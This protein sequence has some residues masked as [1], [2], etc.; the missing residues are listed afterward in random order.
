MGKTIKLT[1]EEVEKNFKD[2]G[3]ILL[4]KEYKNSSTKMK[5]ICPNHGKQKISVNCLRRGIRCPE[6]FNEKLGNYH[7]THGM[8]KTKL[9][10]SYR[11]MKERCYNNNYHHFHRYG[12]RGIKVCD[13][14]LDDFIN[15]K[16][17]AI[18]NKY[19]ES[20]TIDRIDKDKNYEPNNCRWITIQEQQ[21]NKCSVI[22]VC[23]D[24]IKDTI[25]GHSERLGIKH[26]TLAARLRRKY[27]EKKGVEIFY[28]K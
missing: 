20:L 3:Y 11:A 19:K 21:E 22:V 17:W 26:K 28:V 25:K 18:E 24:G 14:W 9:Y 2:A 12:G 16:N 7:R 4:D 6:C 1:Y 8:T 5:Y 27:Y 13:D 23:I 10:N 15:F